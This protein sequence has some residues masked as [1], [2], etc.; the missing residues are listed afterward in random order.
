KGIAGECLRTGKIVNVPDA[1]ADDRFNRDIDRVTGF[2][3]RN[4][5]TFPLRSHDGSLVGTL[6]ALNRTD[7][8][9][10]PREEELALTLSSLAGVA[11]Q[12][13]L[14]INEYAEKQKLERDL[15]VARTIQ[16]ATL[17][18]SVPTARG[19]DFAGFNEP[20]DA[21]GG[22][23][24]DY[25]ALPDGRVVLTIA[26]ATGHGIGPALVVTQYRSM[27][28]ALLL[29]EVDPVTVMER[30]N[31]LF[32]ED[33]PEGMFVTSFLGVLDPAAGEITYVSAGHGPLL[34]HQRAGDRRSEHAA[35]TIPLGVLPSLEVKAC[36]VIRL[37]PG[38]TFLL[39][40]D[41]FFEWADA[42]DEQFGTQRI[43]EVVADQPQAS[44]A[45]L[46]GTIHAKLHAF[47]GD[48]PQK[49]DLTAVVIRRTGVS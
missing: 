41:G 39:M 19:Y 11:V 30:I 8:P 29:D 18:R 25:F 31:T 46:I 26:D 24:Y 23:T 15:A 33:L 48:T 47:A 21:T 36:D 16:Q 38:D 35:T 10:G 44:A 13:Q 45:D 14:L 3:T 4:L 34:H 22:D 43:F 7:G 2:R 17:P 49:D 20:A 9:F 12:R 42:S 37:A 5:L 28:R 1:Y 27:V 40:T 32:G 6:Q